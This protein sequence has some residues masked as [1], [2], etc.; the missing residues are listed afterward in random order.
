MSNKKNETHKNNFDFI[1]IVSALTVLYSHHYS[2]NGQGE[3]GFLNI[4][5]F[6]GAA[7]YVFFSVSGFLVTNSW[8]NDP[9][10]FRF[11]L[12]RFL[13][14]WP[15]LIVLIIG[16]I[17]FLGPLVS[18]L[19]LKDYFSN[20]GTFHYLRWIWLKDSFYLPEVYIDN[21]L[22]GVVNGSLWTIPLEVKCYAV[23]LVL[24][25]LGLLKNKKIYLLLIVL[26]FI[27][28]NFQENPDFSKE[29][30][31]LSLLGSYFIFG[32]FLFLIKEFWMK[33]KLF[34]IIASLISA[35]L[36]QFFGLYHTSGLLLIPTIIIFFGTSS[37]PIIRNFG[38]YGDPSYGIYLYAFP[39]Q[40]FF[41]MKMLPNVDFYLSMA[42]SFFITVFLAYLSWHLIEKHAIKIKPKKF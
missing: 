28:F 3:P 19:P 11:S 24:G 23:L 30:N 26:Y 15:A 8:Y 36:M 9:N 21:I 27:W 25:F 2:L 32:S 12:K 17:F 42:Y 16:T 13:R 29:V 5:T 10:I 1:R 4:T 41:V 39:I 33:Q 40:Q 38:R 20:P 6:G 18:K 34:F 31:Y 37:L 22:K 7:L 35:F 14:I